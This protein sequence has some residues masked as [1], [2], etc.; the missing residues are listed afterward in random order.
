MPLWFVISL[1]FINFLIITLGQLL[2]FDYLCSRWQT[3]YDC[4]DISILSK[5]PLVSGSA[6]G[7]EGQ[8]TVYG[9][10]MPL[11]KSKF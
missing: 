11:S 5:K 1:M 6:I 2:I 9:H 3:R 10:M 7:T 8:L 4:N